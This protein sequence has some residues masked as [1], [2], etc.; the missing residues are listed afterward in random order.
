MRSLTLATRTCAQP[1]DWKLKAPCLSRSFARSG[2]TS[3]GGTFYFAKSGDASSLDMSNAIVQAMGLG[4][5]QDRPL[6]DAEARWGYEMAND[7]LGS[8]ATSAN[9]LMRYIFTAHCLARGVSLLSSSTDQ[10]SE[11][12]SV[13]R[14]HL[15][16]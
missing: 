4:T 16:S 3:F 2:Q 1:S 12:P 9:A 11:S 14:C 8:H 10:R 5:A 15:Y 7:G 13:T 6:N